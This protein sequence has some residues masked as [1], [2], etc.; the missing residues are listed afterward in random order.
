METVKV[1]NKFQYMKKNLKLNSIFHRAFYSLDEN[2]V[3]HLMNEPTSE[4]Q[5][6]NKRV[7]HLHALACCVAT[8]KEI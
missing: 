6:S 4:L 8:I 3:I 7:K 2:E 1:G 5:F